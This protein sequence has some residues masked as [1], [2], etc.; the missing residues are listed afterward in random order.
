[1]VLVSLINVPSIIVLVATRFNTIY[2]VQTTQC[3]A[4]INTIVLLLFTK[5][6]VTIMLPLV[7][8]VRLICA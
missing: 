5:Y 2:L 4:I 6:G 3:M 8:D 7:T 1:M